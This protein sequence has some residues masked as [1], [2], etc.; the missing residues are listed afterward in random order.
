MQSTKTESGTF[1][2]LSFPK[3]NNNHDLLN[4]KS[5]HIIEPYDNGKLMSA[6]VV[7][8]GNGSLIKTVD[9]HGKV[10]EPHTAA[11]MASNISAAIN[12][13]LHLKIKEFQLFFS[14]IDSEAILVDVYDGKTFISPGMLDDVY[15]KQMKTQNIITT[16]K[17]DP[18]KRYN[19]ILKPVIVC[20]E[21][22]NP[23]YVKKVG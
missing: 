5:C 8:N 16:E 9:E 12:I 17:F 19:A 6:S 1:N 20:Y 3:F 18:N 14:V 2:C 15:G 22:G 7:R 10:I 23:V 11:P 21:N 13:A 4:N